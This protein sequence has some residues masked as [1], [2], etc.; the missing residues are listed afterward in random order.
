MA[1]PGDLARVLRE[2]LP[3]CI[4]TIIDADGVYEV[5]GLL[6]YKDRLYF[7]HSGTHSKWYS[8]P[9]LRV[10][11]PSSVAGMCWG[12]TIYKD[13]AFWAGFGPNSKGIICWNDH[14]IWGEVQPAP[15][16]EPWEFYSLCGFGDYLYAG[17]MG[18]AGGVA[19]KERAYV[20]RSPD[21]KTG[22]EKVA[23]WDISPDITTPYLATLGGKL[24]AFIGED[25]GW[26]TTLAKK[27]YSTTDG[28]TW[29]EVTLPP[30]LAV[31]GDV[32]PIF[33]PLRNAWI[34]LIGTANGR[35]YAYDGTNFW[36]M[37]EF[38]G[39][40]V[41]RICTN[42]GFQ[43]PEA[44]IVVARR[45]I[46]GEVWKL[47]LRKPSLTRVFRPYKGVPIDL[48]GFEGS[49]LVAVGW[50]SVP[51]APLNYGYRGHVYR[52]FTPV[53][54][55]P[56]FGQYLWKGESISAGAVSDSVLV[57][58][59]SKKSLYFLSDTAGTLTISV[60]PLGDGNFQTYDSVGIS[61]NVLKPYP[62]TADFAYLRISFD[63]AAKVTAWLVASR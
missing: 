47:D 28:V 8:Y 30:K 19:G 39:Q 38:P 31:P 7:K 21:G 20:Y 56:P 18:R 6:E 12:K 4:A 29:T 9:P 40:T 42:F 35:L 22:W 48:L 15:A 13:V 2:E 49:L 53:E 14:G 59:Y 24:Y 33:D 51:G 1:L 5:A 60:D 26:Y 63:A 11:F 41:M 3:K 52:L 50:E 44:Y 25:P 55:Y 54:D 17:G 62:F 36:L 46:S 57:A 37:R 34:L 23:E 27:C 45:A 43:S 61:A 32:Q 58:G 16:Y 10:E